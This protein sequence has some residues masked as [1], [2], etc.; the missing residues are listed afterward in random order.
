MK[1]TSRSRPKAEISNVDVSEDAVKDEFE[2]MSLEDELP[3]EPT[4]DDPALVAA[5]DKDLEDK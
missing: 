1:A 5:D 2:V 4:S 3:T